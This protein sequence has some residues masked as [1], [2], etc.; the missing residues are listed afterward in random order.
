M[1]L[2][3]LLM[4]KLLELIRPP[5]KLHTVIFFVTSR[6]NALCRT[7]F[8]WEE[9]NKR[10]DL[11]FDEIETLSRTM[12][13]FCDLLLSGGEPS[14]RNDLPRIVSLFYRNNGIRRIYF[15]TNG[16]KPQ[17]IKELV[18]KILEE[19]GLLEVYLNNSIDG[20]PETNDRIRSVPGNFKKSLETIRLA[21]TLKRR[22]GH[23]LQINVNSV[24]CAENYNELIE[25]G[26][27]F[28]QNER[29]DYHYFQIIRGDPMDKNLKRV[30]AEE[31]KKLYREVTKIQQVYAQ[32]QAEDRGMLE[33]WIRKSVYTA[34]FNFHHQIQ[35]N[36]YTEDAPWPMPCTAGET[37]VVIDYDGGVRACELRGSLGN[38]RDYGCDFRAFWNSRI[39][40]D[41]VDSIA[42]DKCFCTHICFL[43]DS[44]RFSP[45]VRFWELPKG[46]FTGHSW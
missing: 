16:L 35:F 29:L 1:E 40:A 46:Y 34:V 9:L 6:C 26:N 39:R 31:L 25:L 32:R 23:R 7:C 27:F 11:T 45:R 5:K 21:H 10:G 19:N 42:H 8:Y 12:P 4:K 15:P 36:N 22:F 44:M 30:P 33:G 18:E 28:L 24:I 3:L 43:H 17:R 14:L 20:L 41:E 38:I 37:A 2:R 13:S